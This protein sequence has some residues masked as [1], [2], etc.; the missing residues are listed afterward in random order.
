VNDDT[1]TVSPTDESGRTFDV[2][3]YEFGP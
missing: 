3:T 2:Q 1:V